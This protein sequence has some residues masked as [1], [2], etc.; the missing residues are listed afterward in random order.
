M[1]KYSVIKII[2]IIAVAALMLTSFFACTDGEKTDEVTVKSI[3]VIERPEGAYYKGDV[4]LTFDDVLLKVEY[5]NKDIV[6]VTLNDSMMSGQDRLKFQETGAHTVTINYDGG[7]GF[8]DFE[9]K[10]AAAEGKYLAT[11]YS[12]GGTTVKSV[13]ATEIKAFS[14]PERSGY[15]FDGW[16]EEAVFDD[17]GNV[18]VWGK[19]AVEPYT[20]TANTSF[21]AKW[22]DNRVCNVRFYDY[23]NSVIYSEEIHYGEKIDIN[24]YKYPDELVEPGRTFIGWNVT[25]GNA[26][27]VTVDLIVKANFSIEKCI[28]KVVYANTSGET[29]EVERTF[30]YGTEFTVG[31]GT[32]YIKPEKEGYTS[33]F[34]MYV[35]HAEDNIEEGEEKPYTELP[36]DQTITLTEPYTTICPEYTILTYKIYIYNGNIE[37]T[38][39]N[40]KNG[41]IEL[42]RTYENSDAQRDFTVE[43]NSGFDF[44]EY[45]QEPDID[46]P[47]VFTDENGISGY[48]GQWCF[49]VQDKSGQEIWYNTAGFIWNGEKQIF[50]APE[51]R[52]EGESDSE[53]TLKDTEDN[54]IAVI[55]NGK[56][57][58]IKNDVTVKALYTKKTYEV[59]LVRQDGGTQKTLI[60]FKV[61]YL[62]DLNIYDQV[63]Y[64][65]SPDVD[66]TQ[67][68]MFPAEN[69][70]GYLV[71]D[72]SFKNKCMTDV[73]NP[74][75]SGTD[76]EKLFLKENTDLSVKEQAVNGGYYVTG[77]IVGEET[78]EDWTVEWYTTS[79]FTSGVIDFK[80][81]ETVEVGRALTLYCKD[82]D[83]R[84]YEVLFFY[85]YDFNSD[86]YENA[87][88]MPNP[89]QEF[90]QENETVNPPITNEQIT[91]EVNGVTVPYVFSGWYDVPYSLYLKT[92][93]RGKEITTYSG[94]K[95]SVYYYAHYECNKTVTVRIY[96]KTQSTAYIGNTAINEQGF[97]YEECL[98]ADDTI[99]YT[100]PVGTVFD[101]SLVYKGQSDGTQYKTSGQ[102]FYDNAKSNAF[103]EDYYNG[104]L[105]TYLEGKFGINDALTNI[106]KIKAVIDAFVADYNTA[107]G[108]VYG[109]GYEGYSTGVGGEYEYYLT[110]F[111][112][113]SYE[114][115]ITDFV[116]EYGNL[117]ARGNSIVTALDEAGYSD[118]LMSKLGNIEEFIKY[119]A[120]LLA[121]LYSEGYQDKHTAFN[122]I[123][124]ANTFDFAGY[125]DNASN[126]V[127]LLTVSNILQEY[128][129]FLKDYESYTEKKVTPLYE[130]S[131]SDLNKAYGYD[132]IVDIKYAFSG[133]FEDENYTLTY[134]TEFSPLSIVLETDII[135]YAKWTDLTRGTEGLVYEEV[136]A[137]DA[138][139]N[140]FNAYVL[141]DFTNR[142]EYYNSENDYTGVNKDYYYV[143]TNDT[144]VIPEKIVTE[145]IDLQVPTAISKYLDK[146]S[147][148]AGKKDTWNVDYKNYYIISK[149][150]YVQATATYDENIKYYKKEDYPVIGIKKGALDRYAVYIT[151]VTVPLNLYFLEEGAFRNCNIVSFEKIK[152]KEG[153]IEFSYVIIDNNRA[154]YQNDASGLVSAEG[155]GSGVLYNVN[156]SKT[157]I[158]YAVDDAGYETY[159]L[160]PGTE[161]IGAY[162]FA[163]AIY[164]TSVTGTADLKAING[165]AFRNAAKLSTIGTVSGTVT[166]ENGLEYIGEG[167]F[168]QCGKID[169]VTVTDGANLSFVGRNAFERTNWYE[170]KRGVITLGFIDSAGNESGII[171][172]YYKGSLGTD[173]D[174]TKKYD[175]D[176]NE[177]EDGIYYAIINGGTKMLMSENGKIV[178]VIVEFDVRMIS[179]YAFDG[180]DALKYTFNGVKEIG[181]RAFSGHPGLTEIVFNNSFNGEGTD[182]GN[183]VFYG[184]GT[185]ITIT[186]ATEEIKTAVISGQNWDLYERILV[187]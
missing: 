18:S 77:D 162:A 10:D 9:V 169:S 140:S 49:V 24:S 82:T 65:H 126:Y 68:T 15:T 12:R 98:V 75:L 139:G 115:K 8:Y 121:T 156:G 94:R 170:S 64:P 4:N 47:A 53:W 54:Y 187:Y 108:K 40:L 138:N 85:G 101:L 119:Y 63:S 109:H 11:F 61:K 135:L 178:N 155:K 136:E 133:W 171:L 70:T 76:I 181:D 17:N 113:V 118:S 93:Y 142:E 91:C 107:L 152:K 69:V 31:E 19:R 145:G 7:V 84:K 79:A 177:S 141:I 117:A 143:T 158:S 127:R 165:Y 62:S 167:S 150:A 180:L 124:H 103:Y 37:Q 2:F 34:V 14:V 16:Y 116:S 130:N 28:V 95:S 57:T 50:E 42:V 56:L 96:D 41:T 185:P 23:D 132:G 86:R 137:E 32:T 78:E 55:K 160:M 72:A 80:A 13:A 30:N 3:T 43:W 129:D 88:V 106:V 58:Q 36:E 89:G 87:A 20:L 59:K 67:G 166:I 148:A 114:N 39:T 33:R 29:I 179:D 44:A 157:I 161:K 46:T 182:L 159:E 173:Y 25:N 97:S 35:N 151:K 122:G 26:D 172:G 183:E 60:T 105:K 99:I 81:G 164:L 149:G 45:T 100:L 111:D 27:E 102:T 38:K 175:I 74:Y 21:Y 90:Y 110:I 71:N 174:E 186:F 92:G 134:Q 146:T 131:L 125:A 120:D 147:E 6:Y 168:S 73:Y 83:N 5:S 51:S 144:G 163:N 176:G 66:G 52:P 184:K 128:M 48:S 153:E 154:I 104:T 123:N 22:I 112:N 1:K